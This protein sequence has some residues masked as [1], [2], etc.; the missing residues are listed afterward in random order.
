M[1]VDKQMSLWHKMYNKRQGKK[2]VRMKGRDEEESRDDLN[3]R[4]ARM[5]GAC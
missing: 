4:A 2:K 5:L 1:S 3:D